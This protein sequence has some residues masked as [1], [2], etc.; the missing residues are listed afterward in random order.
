MPALFQYLI[1]VVALSVLL[2]TKVE[3]RRIALV[4]G[5]N[6]YDNL[7]PDQQLKKAVQDA[8]AVS[9]G[10]RDV[11]FDV[12]TL[13]DARLDDFYLAW[14]TLQRNLA[15]DDIVVVFFAGHGI[16]LEGSNYLLPRDVPRT[17][18]HDSALLRS[19]SILF[20]QLAEDLQKRHVQV[21]V[22]IL[23][24]CRDNPFRSKTGRSLDGAH[25][26]M[27]TEAKGSFVMYSA[28]QGQIA[29]D[30]LVDNDPNPNSVFTRNFLPL[31]QEP[32]LS[33]RDMASRVRDRVA[34][35][36][37]TIGRDQVPAVYDNLR[38]YFAFRPLQDP[39]AAL[40][41]GSGQSFVDT[42]ASGRSC[43][44]C[45]SLV[46]VPAGEFTMGSPPQEFGRIAGNREVQIPAKFE[47]PFAVGKFAITFEEWDACVEN[48]GCNGYHP[49][50]GGF[51]RGTRPVI[52]VGWSEANAFI[53]WLSQKTGKTYRL[54]SET[55]R[56][57]VARAHTTTPFWWGNSSTVGQ[58]NTDATTHLDAGSTAQL[59]LY[60]RLFGRPVPPREAAT[61]V[62]VNSF[63]PN[64]WGL[65]QVHGNVWEWTQ[66]CWNATNTG[67]PG[68]GKARENVDC[69]RRVLRGGAFDVPP[70]AS[71][72]ASRF[73]AP[74]A[75]RDA[76][77]GFRVARDLTN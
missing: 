52:N 58:A 71:R 44:Y 32:G 34:D 3:A 47:R 56:E 16:E 51:G 70:E 66:D 24:A 69:S 19:R 36:A 40:K 6:S 1:A 38:G 77:L 59:T 28:A 14:N 48:S 7:G 22:F 68:D 30:R 50:D 61:T 42:L 20:T 75:T 76:S 63:E 23:D 67:N 11:G 45:P 73:Y 57:Y 49:A 33:L 27:P 39:A 60:Q 21:A 64:G 74:I 4:A 17:T 9:M 37:A 43:P 26:L 41:P 18:E 53:S 10:L 13:E 65:Q 15:P 35:L 2:V 5:V 54:L 62:P 31:L 29:L 46:V 55:E 25:G 72:A 12:T 8:R